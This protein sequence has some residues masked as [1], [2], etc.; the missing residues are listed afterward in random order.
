MHPGG[1]RHQ[2]PKIAH[3]E[4]ASLSLS[5]LEEKEPFRLDSDSLFED[6]QIESVA[7]ETI[8]KNPEQVVI[9]KNTARIQSKPTTG[10][11]NQPSHEQV[12]SKHQKASSS[13]S[14]WQEIVLVICGVAMLIVLSIAIVTFLV[15][16]I[17]A[18]V[19][20]ALKIALWTF[21]GLSLFPIT[22]A[23]ALLFL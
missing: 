5:V 3:Q 20:L 14:S 4:S 17:F 8:E 12:K 11:N 10:T 16:W 1:N 6:L 7:T 13:L 23:I 9:R 18:P 15:S 2:S 19:I 21:C 22:I